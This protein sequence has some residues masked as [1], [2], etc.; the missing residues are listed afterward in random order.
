PQISLET[1]MKVAPDT[2]E[3]ISAQGYSA[4]DATGEM[5]PFAWRAP[6]LDDV[7]REAS[8]LVREL[9]RRPGRRWQTARRGTRL[10]LRRMMRKSMATGGELVELSARNRRPRRRRIVALC[11]VSGSMDL[12]S[13]FLLE[14]LFA[15]QNAGT[16]V[17]SFVFATRLTRVSPHLRE[18]DWRSALRALA[19]EVRDW[20]GGTRIGDALS[21]LVSGW[22]HLIDRYTLTIVLSDGWDTGEPAT[23]ER[24]LAII[25]ERGAR[26]AWLNPLAGKSDYRPETGAMRAAL[27]FLDL[28]APLHDVASLRALRSELVRLA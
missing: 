2:L 15:L 3:T 18:G 10:D 5:K 8:R 17:E 20:S 22:S 7:A 23:I 4:N 24:A 28:L 6:E 16:R 25:K 26:V 19:D 1:W 9:A 14:F 12:Y 13:Q 27:P 21:G 11:D